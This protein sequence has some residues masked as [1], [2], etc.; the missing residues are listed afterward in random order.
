M[1]LRSELPFVTGKPRAREEE[2]LQV[3]IIAHL[4]LR[5]HPD[6]IF[7]AIPNGEHRSK[8]TGARL[9]AQGV[10]AGAPDLAFILPD[11]SPAFMELKATSGRLSPAQKAFEDK[12][13]KLGVAHVVISDIDTALR[14]LE[15]WEIIA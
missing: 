11:G 4:R 6:C 9:K 10:L 7:Y 13:A 5:A 2:Q 8:R 1:M 14:V 15:A 12:C 3:S